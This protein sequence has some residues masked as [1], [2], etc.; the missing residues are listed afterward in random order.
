VCGREREHVAAC[1]EHAG[2]HGGEA[3]ATLADAVARAVVVDVGQRGGQRGRAAFGRWR[4][5]ATPWLL[6][7]A[8]CNMLSCLRRH[9]TRD[10]IPPRAIAFGIPDLRKAL[11]GWIREAAVGIVQLEGRL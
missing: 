4:K 10:P 8:T 6:S 1:V 11:H 9:A 5:K 2:E 3:V 7:L